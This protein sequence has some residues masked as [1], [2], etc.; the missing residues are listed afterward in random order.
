MRVC[1]IHA[2]GLCDFCVTDGD[3]ARGPIC[4]NVIGRLNGHAHRHPV[5]KCDSGFGFNQSTRFNRLPRAIGPCGD[6]GHNLGL[7]VQGIARSDRAADARP[8][9]DRHIDRIDVRAG[10]KQFIAICGNAPHQFRVKGRNNGQPLQCADTEGFFPGCVKIVSECDQRAA[11]GLHRCI[12]FHRVAAR[13]IDLCLQTSGPRRP[14][15]TL[16]V[17]A[18]RGGNNARARRVG[19]A[20]PVNKGDPA[21]HFESA[22]WGMVFVFHPNIQAQSLA[23]SGPEILGRCGHLRVHKAA[24][25]IKFLSGEHGRLHRCKDRGASLY[26]HAK[27]ARARQVARTPAVGLWAWAEGFRSERADDPAPAIWT[28]AL[29]LREAQR[30]LGVRRAARLA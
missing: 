18:A 17:V 9:A 4:I 1:E 27:L 22:G 11:I 23:Q 6:N 2:N 10:G 14:C 24:G 28:L 25:L 21:A 29:F 20:Q 19:A 13:D 15:L 12:L 26:E 5:R 8:A 3:E 16:P 7:V 30:C